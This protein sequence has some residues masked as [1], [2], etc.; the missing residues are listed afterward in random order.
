MSDQEKRRRGDSFVP[1]RNSG[2]IFLTGG[3]GFLALRVAEAL[4]DAGAA[5]TLLVRPDT[6]ER[7]AALRD[8][9]E[10]VTADVWNPGSLRGRARGH[11]AVVHLMG[12]VKP[13]P[14]RGLTFRQ[15]N[16]VS[17]RNVTAMAVNDGVPHMVFLSAAAN[18]PGLPID[19]IESKREAE[20]Y[21]QKSGLAWTILRAPPLYIPGGQRSPLYAV[22]SLLA[23]IPLL[24]MPFRPYAPLSALRMARGIAV[25]ALTGDSHTNRLIRAG[26]LRQIGRRAERQ[27]VPTRHAPP[28]RVVRTEGAEDEPPFGWLPGG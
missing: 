10:V 16:F 9:I 26:E 28:I 25:L 3:T 8:Q 5:V 6:E 15:L 17:A 19:Y 13:D 21:L 20:R 24:G 12:G 22:A 23:R 27:I 7:L 4:L 1:I 11:A 14:K 18:P 2:R